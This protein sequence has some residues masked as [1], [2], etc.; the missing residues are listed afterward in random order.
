MAETEKVA[1]LLQLGDRVRVHVGNLELI[2]VV[3][4]L[5][6]NITL[7]SGPIATVNIRDLVPLVPV[8]DDDEIA[9][10]AELVEIEDLPAP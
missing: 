10:A 6:V 1:R 8:D 2:D 3:R 7:A 5:N 4:D 9:A